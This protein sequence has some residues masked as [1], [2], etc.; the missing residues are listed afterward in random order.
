MGAGK[1]TIGRLLA[2]TMDR[3]FVDID[4][5]IESRTGVPV[6]WVF[7]K[8]GETGFRDRETALLRESAGKQNIIVATGGGSVMRS[9]NRELMANTGFIVFL[10]ASI[11]VQV[12]RTL[13]DKRRPL[14]QNVPDRYETLAAIYKQR[15]S[16]YRS[17]AHKSI[18]TDIGRPHMVIKSILDAISD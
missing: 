6:S 15:E 9:E 12:E 13:K 3:M 18:S 7:D 5:E 11:E 17:L 8:E 2:E 1:S 14:L 4:R 16:I 10:K